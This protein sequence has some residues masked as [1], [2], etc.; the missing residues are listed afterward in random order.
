VKSCI[1]FFRRSLVV[2]SLLLGVCGAPLARAQA[3]DLFISQYIEGSSNNKALELYNG[4]ASPVNL[5]TGQYT[6]EMYFNGG[7]TPNLVHSLTGSVAPN[8][9]FVLSNPSATLAGI[10]GV[11]DQTTASNGWFNGNDVVVL[12]RNNGGTVLDVIG[13]LANN[14]GTEWGTG[15]TST[16]D[17][18]LSRKPGVCAGDANPSDTFEPALEWDGAAIDTVS[19]LGAHDASCSGDAAP[20]VT[21]AKPASGAR[22]GPNGLLAVTFSEPV[23]ASPG[24]FVLSCSL[25]GNVGLGVS[26]GPSTFTLDPAV[27]LPANDNCTLQVNAAQV[28]DQ[29]GAPTSML[30]NFTRAFGVVPC[31]APATLISAVQGSGL[32]TPLAGSVVEIEGVVVGDFQGA[33]GLGG[34]FLQ[35]ETPDSSA[36][37]SEGI[38]VYDPSTSA[39]VQIG[40]VVRA[41]GT[42]T[43]HFE[44]TELN[45]VQWA[46]VCSSGAALPAPALVSLPS[47]T[48]TDPERYEGMRVTFANN[49]LYVTENYNQGR[50]GEVLLA[51]GGRQ[52]APTNVAAPGPQAAAVNAANL[53]ARIELDDG[54]SQENPLPNVPYLGDN[55]TL[56]PGDRLDS[57]TGV[58]GYAFGTYEVH[59]TAPVHFTQTP[60]PASPPS[61]SGRLKL[62]SYNLLNYFTTLDPVGSTSGCGPTGALECRGAN[63]PAEFTRQRVKTKASLVALN[64]DI[65]GLAEVQNNNGT[66]DALAD[67]AAM[68]NE[69]LGAGTYTY[70]NTGAIGTDAIKVGFVYKIATVEVTGS[71]EILQT[72]AFRPTK[73]RPALA[74]TFRERMTGERFTAIMNHLKSKGSGCSDVG[75]P[76]D[77]NGQGECNLTRVAAVEELKRWI[78]NDLPGIT[79]DPDYILL[80]DFNAYAQE[81]PITALEAGGFVSQTK[82]RFGSQTYDY[83]F[84]GA[85]GALS[86][87]LSNASMSAQVSGI[88]EW[89]SNSDE[90]VAF[91][92]NDY[93]QPSAY[94]PNEWRAADHDPILVGLDLS[95]G[96]A[97][98]PATPWW[99][100][101]LSLGLL[102]ALGA[103]YA[104][105]AAK[106]LG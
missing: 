33:N 102:G 31:G 44:L 26:G 91:D 62:V 12:R 14:P 15:L 36:A 54:S 79:G 57:L 28:T 19:G 40:D 38:F 74:V 101:A 88:L 50:Y 8:D 104:R 73:N 21:D 66:P 80:G 42:A 48:L 105:R 41:R 85:A 6:I 2:K 76:L 7:T 23:T 58:L 84:E 68:L 78:A 10:T 67:V 39:E 97:P 92:Y 89:H 95:D 13:Q 99:S 37:T 17:N 72:T 106:T 20:A 61:V 86:N 70:V 16:A 29:D 25:A 18:T 52:F 77:P 69:A 83:V 55:G 45:A 81:D 94:Q 27:S 90:P 49:S 51:A 87:V 22:I 82:S 75:D 34:F 46:G 4:T 47:T 96:P 35:E 65:Y 100:I 3:T 59:P 64:A 30:A 103:L 98:V 24:A 53:L 43:E 56:R 63:T 93:N 11:S 9:V 71:P 1:A 60:R 32:A 5:A